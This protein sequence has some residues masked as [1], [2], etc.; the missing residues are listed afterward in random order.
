MPRPDGRRS[1]HDGG[2]S[3]PWASPDARRTITGTAFGRPY[4]HLEPAS[5]PVGQDL[6]AGVLTVVVSVLVAA[7]VGLLWAAIAP[8]VGV[9]VAAGEVN[10]ADTYGDSFIAVDGYFFGA[11]LVAGLVG[12]L[13]AWRL[14]HR[15]GPAVVVGLAVG[16]VVAAYV[17]KTVGEQVGLQTLRDAVRAGGEGAFDLNVELKSLA[18]LAGWPVASLAAYVAATLARGR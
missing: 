3:T 17:A 14:G 10:L 8:H 11:V 7:P 2:V 4:E 6:L 16:G 5:P 1:G 12:G 15:H 9:V 18:A 13:V